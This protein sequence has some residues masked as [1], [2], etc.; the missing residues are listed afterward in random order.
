M[1]N[2]AILSLCHARVPVAIAVAILAV[3]G[4][5]AVAQ[6]N[7]APPTPR[8]RIELPAA[9]REAVETTTAPSPSPTPDELLPTADDARALKPAAEQQTTIEQVRLPNRSTEV[10]VTPAL[11][12]RTWT[13]TT[14]EGQQPL[15]PTSTSPGLSVPK[16]FTFEFGGP[17]DAPARSAPP[18]PSSATPR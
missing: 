18:P 16:F 1:R 4:K 2:L 17:S 5:P 15:S 14:R 3:H 6:A 9:E 10:R 7:G 11:T 13:M 8:T 12:G